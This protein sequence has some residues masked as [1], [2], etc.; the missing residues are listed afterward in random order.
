MT[1]ADKI[2]FYPSCKGKSIIKGNILGSGRANLHTMR[3]KPS[4]IL[5]HCRMAYCYAETGISPLT[6]GA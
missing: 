1:G 3:F 4:D 6:E 5:C 2:G